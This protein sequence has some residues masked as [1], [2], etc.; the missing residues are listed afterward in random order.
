MDLKHPKVLLIAQHFYPELVSTGLHMTE[1][2]TKWKELYPEVSIKVFT[3]N[4]TK[5]GLKEKVIPEEE[6]KGVEIKRVKSIGK[7]H[8]N[9]FNRIIFSL[10]FILKTLMYLLKNANKHDVFLITTNPPFLGILIL[11]IHKLFKKPYIIIS[12]DIYPQILKSLNIIKKSNIIYK[13]WY[14]LN[15][16]VYKNS[17]KVVS[18]GD[19]MTE[20]LLSQIGSD[21]KNKIELIHNWSD[22]DSVNYISPEKNDFLK[23]QNLIDKK[24]LLYSG[25]FGATHNIEDI[26]QAS[27]ELKNNIDILFLFIGGGAKEKVLINFIKEHKSENIILLPFQ[28]FEMLSQTLSSATISIV[29]LDER[30]TGLSVPSKTYGLMA[31][32]Q[33]ILALVC[34]NSEI[35]KTIEKFKFGKVW[36]KSSQQNLS[37]LI[38]EM[39]DNNEDLK[40]MANNG[41]NAF[42]NNFNIDIS[43]KKYN[44]LLYS[45]INKY[46]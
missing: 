26:L 38:L 9:I 42:I 16:I 31:A 14:H 21:Y 10:G 17:A 36:N 23:S 13:L 19:D 44:G 12:Y 37:A 22:K 32:K 1:L 45:I 7:Q 33:P 5:K 24:I 27:L 39:L 43:V 15:T 28:P 6:Y 35:A 3:S 4:S 41:Y 8:G 40:T 11:L 30:F 25:T 34:N 18:I 2:T 46:D 20:I 29:C